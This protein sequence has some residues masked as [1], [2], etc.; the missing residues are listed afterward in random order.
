MSIRW[1]D[2]LAALPVCALVG[3]TAAAP[4][5]AHSPSLLSHPRPSSHPCSYTITMVPVI[6]YMA[7]AGLGLDLPVGCQLTEGREG[8]CMASAG[9]LF[10]VTLF[11][12]T[13][14]ANPTP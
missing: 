5:A 13:L 7:S 14:A 11:A 1:W 6:E 4:S 10:A 3:V 8:K 9:T 2:G 12:V